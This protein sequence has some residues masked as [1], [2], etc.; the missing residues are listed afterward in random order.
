MLICCSFSAQYEYKISI[1]MCNSMDNG[2]NTYVNNING[3]NDSFDSD[4]GMAFDGSSSSRNGLDLGI[5]YSYYL[6]QNIKTSLSLLYRQMGYRST[7][8]GSYYDSWNGGEYTQQLSLDSKI[9]LNYG[10][11]S[12][13]ITYVTNS[14]FNVSGGVGYLRLTGGTFKSEGLLYFPNTPNNSQ[15]Y[16]EIIDVASMNGDSLNTNQSNI[17]NIV[18]GSDDASFYDSSANMFTYIGIGYEWGDFN[19]DMTYS[20]MS[21]YAYTEEDWDESLNGLSISIGYSKLIIKK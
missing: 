11:V 16:D 13:G 18:L 20:M 5:S 3:I 10:G 15:E 21:L 2:Y 6:N 12:A 19:I 14:G 17:T 7:I 4:Y 9:N 8:N 1:G